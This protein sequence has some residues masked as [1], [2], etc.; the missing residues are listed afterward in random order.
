MWKDQAN[1]SGSSSP[2]G[3]EVCHRGPAQRVGGAELDH[4]VEERVDLRSA[5][6]EPVVQDVEGRQQRIVRGPG[7]NDGVFDGVVAHLVPAVHVSEH[8]RFLRGEVP[9]ERGLGHP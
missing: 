2:D 1:P 7:M 4:D 6:A 5:A 8:E 3:R 9:V